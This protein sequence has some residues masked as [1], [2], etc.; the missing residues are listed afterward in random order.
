M[1]APCRVQGEI[2][3]LGGGRSLGVRLADL[4]SRDCS[5]GETGIRSV[6]ESHAG[7]CTSY[8]SEPHGFFESANIHK[9]VVLY[10][11]E[12]RDIRRSKAYSILLLVLPQ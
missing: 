6:S 9:H 12:A 10:S 8:R 7:W 2:L 1:G 3:C 5:F 11:L 4:W